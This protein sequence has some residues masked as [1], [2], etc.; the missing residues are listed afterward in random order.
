MNSC[1]V[2]EDDA[3]MEFILDMTDFNLTLNITS[4][5][6]DN[7]HVYANETFTFKRDKYGMLQHK[8]IIFN[9]M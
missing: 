8:N 5:Q 1:Y 3:V 6:K 4:I 9:I 2:H 7:T